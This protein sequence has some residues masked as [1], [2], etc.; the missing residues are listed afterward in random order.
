MTTTLEFPALKEALGKQE[1]K[2]KELHSIFEEAGPEL[3]FSKI[4]SISGDTRA[5]AARVRELNNELKA[6]AEEVEDLKAVGQ[7]SEKARMSP[8]SSHR[9]SGSG[10][11][12]TGGGYATG[13]QARSFGDLFVASHA[14]KGRQGQIGPMATLDI[15]LKTLM[16]TTA[17]F[18]PEETRTGRVVEFATRRQTR[19]RG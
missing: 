8:A 2:E 15:E 10:S 11:G 19:N 7:A 9:E 12:D 13:G 17:G 4:K 5:K 14:Y 3:D 1:V 6:L 16:T 18:D